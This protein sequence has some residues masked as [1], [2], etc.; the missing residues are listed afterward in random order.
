MATAFAVPT[1]YIIGGEE[2]GGA[3]DL[4]ATATDQIDGTLTEADVELSEDFDENYNTQRI[5]QKKRQKQVTPSDLLGKN[6]S[7]RATS[8]KTRNE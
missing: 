3:T 2:E 5:Q 4:A 6:K 7:M 1:N 8:S